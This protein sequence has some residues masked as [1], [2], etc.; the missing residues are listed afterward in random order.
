[1]IFRVLGRYT[2]SAT[3]HCQIVLPR[4]GDEML[5]LSQRVQKNTV[6]G[7]VLCFGWKLPEAPISEVNQ[8]WSLTRFQSVSY[9]QSWIVFFFISVLLLQKQNQG[10]RQWFLI[11]VSWEIRR[12]GKSMISYMKQTEY[13]FCGQKE[14]ICLT[15]TWITPMSILSWQGYCFLISD[16]DFRSSLGRSQPWI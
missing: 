2:Y 4:Q 8:V 1:M 7:R 10:L 6:T 12:T 13:S 11:K 3:A 15:F 5:E 9:L 14:W 16:G